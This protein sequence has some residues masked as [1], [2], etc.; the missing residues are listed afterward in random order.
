MS[1]TLKSNLEI[2]PA[3]VVLPFAT[4]T[5]PHIPDHPPCPTSRPPHLICT[6]RAKESRP[7]V[8]RSSTVLHPPLSS[9]FPLDALVNLPYTMLRRV[10]TTSLCSAAR[11]RVAC[12]APARAMTSTSSADP[13][14]EMEAPVAFLGL[15]A[16]GYPMAERLRQR[17]TDVFVWNRS[18]NVAEQHRRAHNTNVISEGFD[19]LAQVRAVFLCLPTSVEVES[20]LRKVRRVDEQGP[21][22]E[23]WW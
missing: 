11:S 2:A 4:Q 10:G 15:G 12:S 23:R 6:A 19:E 17:G 7:A 14:E 21:R 20:T 13:A 1:Y 8:T 5:T 16:M 18:V 3:I 9:S 22:G